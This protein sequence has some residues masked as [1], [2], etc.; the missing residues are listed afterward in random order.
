MQ[1]NF[2]AMPVVLKNLSASVE[3]LNLGLGEAN[4]LIGDFEQK[5]ESPRATIQNS[6][7]YSISPSAESLG[8]V[9]GSVLRILHRSISG[10]VLR[11]RSHQDMRETE[12]A[13]FIG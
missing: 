8:N 12:A 4:V 6:R 7:C 10:I 1:D 3:F 5:R 11:H 2:W 13:T 9:A